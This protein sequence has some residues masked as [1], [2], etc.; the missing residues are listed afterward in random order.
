[1]PSIQN[2]IVKGAIR[3]SIARHVRLGVGST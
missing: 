3:V 1:M 2:R